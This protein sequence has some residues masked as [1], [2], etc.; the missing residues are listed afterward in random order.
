M[1]FSMTTEGKH[2]SEPQVTSVTPSVTV[3]MEMSTPE[4][5]WMRAADP[6]MGWGE[7]LS[8][9]KSQPPLSMTLR[10]AAIQ[11]VGGGQLQC[12]E[13][14]LCAF[15]RA[16][17]LQQQTHFSPILEAKSLIQRYLQG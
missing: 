5:E 12:L 15:A 3:T 11:A 2:H 10:G 1:C 8:L 9:E 13:R 17:W 6:P 16:T 14:S 4:F 7:A